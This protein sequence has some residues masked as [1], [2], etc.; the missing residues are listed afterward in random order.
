MVSNQAF[1]PNIEQ[2]DELIILTDQPLSLTTTA[3]TH[4]RLLSPG[5]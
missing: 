1:L 3:T 5:F 2:S 4:P